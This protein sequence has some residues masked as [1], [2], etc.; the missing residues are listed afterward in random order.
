MLSLFGL[1]GATYGRVSDL[2]TLGP[3]DNSQPLENIL[4]RKKVQNFFWTK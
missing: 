1:L 4:K 2:V 3:S